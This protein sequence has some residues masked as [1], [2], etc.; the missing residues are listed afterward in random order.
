MST[1]TLRPRRPLESLPLSHYTALPL[2]PSPISLSSK[3]SLTSSPGRIGESSTSKLRKVSGGVSGMDGAET[4]RRK[5]SE[6]T[7][8][9][10]KALAEDEMGIGKSPARRL[11]VDDGLR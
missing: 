6:I 11:F 3:R 2:P 10:K 1:I 5:K 8:R 4:I 7:P 9:A